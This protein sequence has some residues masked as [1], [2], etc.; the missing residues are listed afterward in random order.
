MYKNG[1]VASVVSD[2]RIVEDKNEV[3]ALPFGS[4]YKLRLKNKTTRDAVVG[5]FIDS[6]CATEQ[7]DLIVHANSMVELERF[8]S[9]VYSGSKFK[10]VASDPLLDKNE[11][12]P[13]NGIVE[14]RFR[15]TKM[16]TERIIY[17]HPIEEEHHYYY[18]RVS[19]PKITWTQPLPYH[20]NTWCV[21]ATTTGS[22]NANIQYCNAISDVSDGK[23]VEGSHSDQRFSYS[24]IGALEETET[25]IRLRL[26][27]FD[28]KGCCTEPKIYCSKCGK[29]FYDESKFC[30]VCGNKLPR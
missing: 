26:V 9:N 4:E 23:T 7:G 22:I 8:V 16:P 12:N 29:A 3:V 2:G 21:G 18:P 28:A 27:G 17:H 19:S 25:V 5:V 11:D 13:K 1:F 6:K 30:S 20:T 24:Y 14:I 15:L 10:F